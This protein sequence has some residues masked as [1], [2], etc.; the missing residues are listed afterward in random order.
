M[1]SI[2]TD[3][4]HREKLGW[5]A[6]M[7]QSMGAIHSNFDVVGLPAQHDAPH[8]RVPA[9]GRADPGHR[10]RVPDLRR[11][12]PRRRQL[13]RRVHHHAVL[14]LA[15]P[16]ATR[17]RCASTTR[18]CRPTWPTCAR[19][20]RTAL[21]VSG[22]GDWIGGRHDDAE[23]GDRHLRPVR[24]RRPD[25]ADGGRARADR[26]RRRLPRAG[27]QPRAP[28]S[29]P[30]FF[31][32]ATKTYTTAGPA[33]TT[34]LA[35]AG[36]AAAGHGHRAPR[37]PSSRVL[38][39]LVARIDAYHPNGSGPHISGGEVSLQP[40]YRVADGQTAAATCCGTSCRSRARRATPTSSAQGRTTIPES[41][42]F[43]GS[44]NHMILLQ[45]DEWFNAGLAGIQQA[46]GSAATTRWSSSRRRSATL[47]HVA[48][49]YD[50]A[51]RH[52]R[53][54]V[55]QGRQRRAPR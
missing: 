16:T 13:G 50:V 26:R 36:R 32:P 19:S 33:G 14:A 15:R 40:I 12:L 43:A 51:A 5:L 28:R 49:T 17:A 10:A 30:R 11:R 25:G 8:G 3:C 22:L 47:T 24:D 35:G 31:N 38:D 42:D 20:R 54:R 48:G 41:W 23:G 1:Q 18:R 6:D 21:L 27:R 39:D 52:D 34:G 7:I 2:F 37:T 46:P 55:D 53:E 45:I 9:A 29:T 44:Q 4:P